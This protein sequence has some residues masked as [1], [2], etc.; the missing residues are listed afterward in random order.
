[1]VTRRLYCIFIIMILVMLLSC[2]KKGDK[3]K[4]GILPAIDS[5]PLV[6]ADAEGLFRAE[7]IDLELLMFNSALEKE[8]AVLSSALHGSFGDM[9]TALLTLKSGKDVRIFA[10]S[11]RT[12]RNRMFALVASPGAG[13][14]GIKSAPA[15]QIAISSGSVIEFFLDEIA[16]LKGIKPESLR[17][18]EVKGIPLRYQMVMSGQ[19]KLA[20]LPEP[21]V[22]KAEKEGAIVIADDRGLDVTATVISF[23]GDFL[24]NNPSFAKSFTTAYNKSVNMINSSPEK[25]RELLVSRLRLPGELMESFP[26]PRY[27]E[28]NP[29][30]EKDIQQVYTWMKGKGLLEKLPDYEKIIWK[31]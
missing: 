10:E 17:K 5:L 4:V 19:V 3:I 21:L 24:E 29:P 13:L 27:S 8:S 11:S 9:V 25:Y 1:M 20:M 31:Q 26:M 12:G 14:K 23:R 16:G 18:L 7:G 6:V 30:L 22:S 15:E 28:V 2:S